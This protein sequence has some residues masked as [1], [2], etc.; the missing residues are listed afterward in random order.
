MNR[1]ASGL[2]S[3]WS[4]NLRKPV[5][6]LGQRIRESRT[7]IELTGLVLYLVLPSLAW[8]MVYRQPKLVADT[9]LMIPI[10]LFLPKLARPFWRLAWITACGA[11]LLL[12][13]N[14]FFESYGFYAHLLFEIALTGHGLAII[15]AILFFAIFLFLPIPSP[16]RRLQLLAIG[17]CAYLFVIGVKALPWGKEHLAWIRIPI[18]RALQVSISDGP[19]AFRSVLG[20]DAAPVT[21]R[22]YDALSAR[23]EAAPAKILIILVESWGERPADL[24]HIRDALAAMPSVSQIELGYNAFHGSTL[25]A[26][27]RELCGMALD[28]AHPEKLNRNCLPRRFATAGYA[29]TAFHGYDGFFYSR[30][31]IYPGLGFQRS[32]FKPDLSALAECAG[33]FNGACDDAVVDN[34]VNLLARPGRQFVYMMSLTA[35]APVAATSLARPYATTMLSA[36]PG[37]P[38]QKLNRALIVRAVQRIHATMNGQ[39]ALLYI[40]GDHNPP[41]AEQEFQVPAGKTPYLLIRLSGA[42]QPRNGASTSRR[43]DIQ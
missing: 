15:G 23:P 12:E 40:A 25:P 38:G 26:E 31:I 21:H 43:A 7:T 37:D 18:V 36:L 11:M 10:E 17:T 2:R 3:E 33:A 30:D 9:L 22:L 20:Q 39:D 24:A 16:K 6:A 14:I 19:R 8:S 4:S 41:G 13:W 1:W 27:V 28:F 34:A 5:S 35:H 42:A 29:T 32:Y